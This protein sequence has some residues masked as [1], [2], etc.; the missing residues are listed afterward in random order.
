VK[1]GGEFLANLPQVNA[2]KIGIY[3]GSYGGYLTALALARDSELFKVGVD[4]HGVHDLD[5]RYDL[6][7]GYEVA[8]DYEEAKE[9]AWNSSPIADL[10]T[11]TSPVL[12][13]HSD[14]DRN[15]N[16]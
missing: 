5:G 13:I 3:G 6:P 12:F 14:D 8:Q 11:W 7:E 2:D 9:I 4:I 16:V 15:V 1:A 10:D